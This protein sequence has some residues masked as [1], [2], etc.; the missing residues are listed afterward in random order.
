MQILP[1]WPSQGDVHPGRPWVWPCLQSVAAPE[2][3]AVDRSL[4][5]R[6]SLGGTARHGHL[7]RWLEKA[8]VSLVFVG[9]NGEVWLLGSHSMQVRLSHR[10][11]APGGIAQALRA[12]VG[13]R[14]WSSV[15]FFP[16]PGEHLWLCPSETMLLPVAREGH[17]PH[18]SSFHLAEG[19][20]K[21]LLLKHGVWQVPLQPS[22]G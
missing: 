22:S 7:H 8:L 1:L 18:E 15:I 9:S 3:P 2:C 21:G 11:S 5:T 14:E 17:G 4:C 19:L 13:Q 12:A 6:M 10:I 20:N 16:K